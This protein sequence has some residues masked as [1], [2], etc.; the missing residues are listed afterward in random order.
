MS[1]DDRGGPCRALRA[2]VHAS[3]SLVDVDQPDDGAVQAR[4]GDDRRV[5]RNRLLA[6]DTRSNPMLQPHA[7][8]VS[9]RTVLLRGRPRWLA[10]GRRRGWGWRL[11]V[12]LVG[13]ETMRL[14]VGRRVVMVVLM[15]MGVE[16][17]LRR[18]GRARGADADADAH[19]DADSDSDRGVREGGS[20]DRRR[21]DRR[22]R[23]YRCGYRDR[24][25]AAGGRAGARRRFVVQYRHPDQPLSRVRHVRSLQLR[26]ELALPLVPPILEP[27][28][29]L[30]LGEPERGRQ[31]GSLR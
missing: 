16:D 20:R 14:Y 13:Q 6:H 7:A 10:V 18:G 11:R 8:L 9:R 24:G 23:R 29:H 25:D 21:D 30:G 1:Q 2:S 26:S 27:D 5:H 31:P 17:R 28:L 4:R 3:P 12:H 15:V 19:P 22:R